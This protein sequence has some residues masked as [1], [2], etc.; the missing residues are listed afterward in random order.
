MQLFFKG[1]ELPQRDEN[2][3]LNTPGEVYLPLLVRTNTA[4]EILP[5][6]VKPLPWTYLTLEKQDKKHWVTDVH[7]GIRTPYGLRRRGRV[8]QLAIALR[9]APGETSI[10]FHARHSTKQSLSGY[11]VFER[12]MQEDKSELLGLTDSNGAI[13]ILPNDQPVQILFLRSDGQ[14]LAKVPVAPGA[15]QDIVV[16]VGDDPARL[17]AQA[18]LMSLREEL[19]DLVARRNILMAR[20][21]DRLKNGKFGEAQDLFAE[22]DGLPSR[23]Q[24][25]QKID[26]ATNNKLNRSTDARIQARIDKMFDDTRKLLGRFLS[27]GDLTKLKNEILSV[28]KK[29]G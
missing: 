19:I 6:N 22:L 27:T 4:G 24:F 1:N 18:A 29:N 13:T 20:V 2:L 9:F 26:T 14:L 21:R 25:A 11:E 8:Q 23:S 7:S 15:V 10:R 28:Q 17:R 16:P 12:D 5:E 3:S